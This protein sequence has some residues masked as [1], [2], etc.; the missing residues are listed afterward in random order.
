M[1]L[2]KRHLIHLCLVQLCKLYVQMKNNSDIKLDNRNMINY[3]LNL[4]A[5]RRD[6][7]L[8]QCWMWFVYYEWMVGCCYVYVLEICHTYE[9]L[10]TCTN[11]YNRKSKMRNKR[12]RA[13]I[14]TTTILLPP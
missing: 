2:H 12:E 3:K 9:Y 13:K 14:D 4:G 10:I 5:P 8:Y 6:S 11:N 1:L 7:G